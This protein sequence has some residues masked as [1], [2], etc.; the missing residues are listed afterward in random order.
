MI[1][2]PLVPRS[3]ND[4]SS[5]LQARI[6]RELRS[7]ERIVWSSKP[8]GRTL[9]LRSLPTVLFGIPWTLFS[10]FWV[11]MAAGGASKSGSLFAYLFPLFGVPFVVLGL[12]MLTGPFWAARSAKQTAY[13]LTNQRAITFTPSLFGNV[14]IRSFD[15]A[16]MADLR[17][18]ERADG[19]GD[20]VFARD[21]NGDTDGRRRT[22]DVGFIGVANVK[23]VE[24]RVR[25][26]ASDLGRR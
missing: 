4:I 18:M 14:T 6:D 1:E 7:D 10:C 3:E 22:I 19:S 5:E 21:F 24:D 17:R 16:R 13:V 8:L 25:A 9:A 23:D 12:G 2:R 20:L 15:A 11:V 26:V